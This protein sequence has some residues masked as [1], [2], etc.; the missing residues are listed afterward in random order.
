MHITTRD[1]VKLY[2]EEAGQGTPILFIHEFGGNYDAWE[3]QMRRFSRRHRCITYAARGYKPSDIPTDLEQYSQRIAVED[4]LA[5]LDALGIEKAHIVGLSMGGF[6]TAHFGLIAPERALSLTI[7]GAGYGAEKQYEEYFRGVSLSVAENFETR[8]AKE[9]SKI[10]GLGAS[11][12]QFQ[13]KD[14]RGWAEFS[15][16]LSNHDD[17]GAALTMRGVQAR[18]PSLYDL[19]A[20]FARMEVPT[21]VMTGDEDDHC[22]QTSVYL[23]KTI[24]ACGLAIFP[25]TGHTLNL[26]EP[27]LFNQLLAEFLAQVEAGAWT[28]R[29]P[30]ADP[31]QVMRTT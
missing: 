15:E 12:V 18:R 11:R 21:L 14:P 7:A 10:Y 16:R 9:F 1:G 13:N 24:P 22:I 27:E 31:G 6:A 4:A 25:K 26:E 23:K 8:G 3:P 19:E 2:V 20:E 30:R 28:K 17:L 29:D 5:V